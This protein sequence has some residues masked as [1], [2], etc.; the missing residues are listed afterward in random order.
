MAAKNLN[1]SKNFFSSDSLSDTVQTTVTDSKGNAKTV[2][3]YKT[4]VIKNFY[5]IAEF[6]NFIKIPE[7]N[8]ITMRNHVLVPY[9][10]NG[11]TYFA[12]K[13][14]L[15]YRM[16]LSF[17]NITSLPDMSNIRRTRIKN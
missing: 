1:P 8:P 3:Q 14:D 7:N 11:C 6:Y 2:R 9:P 17:Q 12:N 4:G 15:L 13:T 10:H 5:R 16:V